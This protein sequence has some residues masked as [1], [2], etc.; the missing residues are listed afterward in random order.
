MSDVPVACTSVKTIYNEYLF[1]KTK[2]TRLIT[3]NSSIRVI[4][5]ILDATLKRLDGI[6]GISLRGDAGLRGCDPFDEW[7]IKNKG[8]FQNEFNSIKQLIQQYNNANPDN[9]IIIPLDNRTPYNFSGG[10]TRKRKHTKTNKNTKRNRR[11]STVNISG[12]YPPSNYFKSTYPYNYFYP[13]YN[14]LFMKKKTAP[15]KPAY[16]ITIDMELYPGT[17]LTPNDIY[18]AKCNSKYNGI[19]KAYSILTGTPYAMAPLPTKQSDP[20]KKGGTR[21]RGKKR[22]KTMKR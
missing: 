7:Y 17:S 14:T 10:M 5:K 16:S 13:P 15:P 6:R 19:R 22:N 2:L 8:W 18:K 4:N 1:Q 11:K 21:R 12:G 3:S 20:S 9:H